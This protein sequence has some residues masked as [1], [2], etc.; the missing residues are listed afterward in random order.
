MP[1]PFPEDL[2]FVSAQG[3]PFLAHRLRRASELILEG[4]MPF[5]H[6]NGYDGPARSVSTMLLLRA[7]EALGVTEIAHRLRLTHPLIIKLVA[8][9]AEA[10]LVTDEADPKD[11]RRRVIRLTKRGEE[12]ADRLL[13][14][15]AVIAATLKS[16]F[17]EQDSDFF[18]ALERF[19]QAA[20]ERPI[21]R[22]LDEQMAKTKAARKERA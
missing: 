21:E 14:L 6:R 2:D 19:E 7:E 18:E 5:V 16:M 8:A 9:L 20:R 1:R 13:E 22:R 12:Q 4:T 17:E 11:A 10:G 15:N 3:L